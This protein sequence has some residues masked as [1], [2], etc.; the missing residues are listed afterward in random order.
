MGELNSVD[1]AGHFDIGE[2]RPDIAAFFEHR[3][4]LDSGPR[5]DNVKAGLLDDRDGAP[6]E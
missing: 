5:L 1:G 3:N 6:P 2:N 4:G